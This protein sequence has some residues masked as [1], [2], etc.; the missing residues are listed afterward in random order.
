MAV[1][2]GRQSRHS[3][4]RSVNLPTHGL[5]RQTNDATGANTRKHKLME[6]TSKLTSQLVFECIQDL[7]NR[8][9]PVTRE[10]LAAR[11]GV[12]MMVVDHHIKQLLSSDRIIKV[13][14]GLYA[15]KFVEPQSRAVSTTFLNNG[16]IKLEIGDD[17]LQLTPTES[18]WIARAMAGLVGA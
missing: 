1:L 11:F 3:A 7:H 16:F 17:V 2:I 8:E 18:R 6:K 14:A 10:R 15:P 4:I 12:A 13:R 9:I 5:D